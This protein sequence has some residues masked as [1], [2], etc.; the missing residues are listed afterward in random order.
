MIQAVSCAWFLQAPAQAAQP[1]K[2]KAI[3]WPNYEVHDWDW[4]P[5]PDMAAGS[6]LTRDL[7]S[8]KP[9]EKYY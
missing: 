9:T 2:V 3:Y 6:A 7:Q 8:Q 5:K 1:S 4:N